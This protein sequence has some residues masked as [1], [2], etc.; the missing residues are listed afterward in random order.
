MKKCIKCD[1]MFELHIEVEYCEGY[2]FEC[3]VENC[4]CID[5][6]EEGSLRDIPVRPSILNKAGWVELNEKENI[7]TGT[8]PT[9]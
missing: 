2:Y 3:D 1:H 4:S 9:R 5:G 8:S 6:I 7:K